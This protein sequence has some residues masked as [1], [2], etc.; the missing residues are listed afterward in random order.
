MNETRIH[1]HGELEEV[2]S[3]LI[4][5]GAMV[6]ETIGRGT[7]ALLDRDLHAAQVLID[8]DDVIDDF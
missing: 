8:G 5:L 6:S 7:A 1:Y 2:R 3:D 4:R